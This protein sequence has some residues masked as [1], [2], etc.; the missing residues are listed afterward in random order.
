MQSVRDHYAN[1]LGSVYSWMSGGLDAALV[2]GSGE[3]DTLGLSPRTTG[4]AVDLGAGFGMH[5]IPLAR[6]GF[7]VLAVDTSSELLRELAAHAANLPIRVAEADLLAFRDH[8]EGRA[9]AV[10]CMGDTLTHLPSLEAVDELFAAVAA[11]LERGGVMVLTFRDYTSPLLDDRRFIPV[12]SDSDRIMTC[13]LEYEEACVNVHDLLHE[14]EGSQW[15]LRVSSYRK[16]RLA[17]NWVA[18]ALEKRGFRVARDTGLG[19]M[20]RLVAHLIWVP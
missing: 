20:V 10:L 1:H 13:F 7:S 15:R 18:D 14:R 5:S 9:E 8:L 11:T 16:L 6:R 17:A 4:Q 19:G 2:R 3:I 12:H